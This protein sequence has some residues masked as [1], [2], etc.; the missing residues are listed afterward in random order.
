MIEFR[1]V[2]EHIEVYMNNEFM[3][4]ADN[5]SEAEKELEELGLEQ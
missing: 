3:F 1:H 2:M 4:S 5:L